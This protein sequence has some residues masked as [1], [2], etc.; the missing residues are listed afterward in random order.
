M[1]GN[2]LKRIAFN[3]KDDNNSLKH[4]YK[5]IITVIDSKFFT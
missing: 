1:S 2:L 5:Y 3:L 4:D